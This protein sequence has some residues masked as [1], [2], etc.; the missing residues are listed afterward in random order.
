MRSDSS[1]LATFGLKAQLAASTY[2]DLKRVE[3]TLAMTNEDLTHNLRV[4]VQEGHDITAEEMLIIS[5]QIRQGRRA[6]ARPFGKAA[7][8]KPQEPPED[9]GALLDQAMI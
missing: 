1:S 5:D 7:K 2:T 9:L 6:A 3:D 4:R 8:T